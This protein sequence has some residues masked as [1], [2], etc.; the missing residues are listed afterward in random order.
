MV[1]Q[2]YESPHLCQGVVGMSEL[3]GVVLMG[4]GGSFILGPHRGFHMRV[5]CPKAKRI[6]NLVKY[7]ERTSEAAQAEVDQSDRDRKKFVSALFNAE[8]DDPHNYDMVI[9]SAL[10]DVEEIVEVAAQAVEGKMAKLTWL[11]HDQP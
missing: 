1:D 8:I 7:K 5:I 9:N 2:D 11:D 3:G 4:R 6:E 10:I